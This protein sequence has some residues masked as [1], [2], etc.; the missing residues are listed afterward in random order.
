MYLIDQLELIYILKQ[1]PMMGITYE[2]IEKDC[3]YITAM[4]MRNY[5]RG[6]TRP[7][8]KK[9]DY[10]KRELELKYPIEYNAAKAKFRD[11]QEGKVK[12]LTVEQIERLFKSGF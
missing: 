10:L 9:F 2:M 7:K 5:V 4:T 1:F 12:E 11:E 8:G 3:I 6:K